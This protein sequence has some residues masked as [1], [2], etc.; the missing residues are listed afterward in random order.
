MNI[1]TCTTTQRSTEPHNPR[2]SIPNLN[3]GVTSRG[4]AIG[5]LDRG[6]ADPYVAAPAEGRILWVSLI[7]PRSLL[8]P[9]LDEMLFEGAWLEKDGQARI[10]LLGQGER[11]VAAPLFH[12]PDSA[13]LW[14]ASELL[15]SASDP[16][17]RKPHDSPDAGAENLAA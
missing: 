10:R 13:R 15:K 1:D 11:R 16:A 2:A 12:S 5:H 3:L 17:A 8:G 14:L 9:L 7:H 4:I 6:D